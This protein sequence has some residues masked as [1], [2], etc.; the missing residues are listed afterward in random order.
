VIEHAKIDGVIDN[1]TDKT[2]YKGLPVVPIELV[3]DNALVVVVVVIGKPLLA[4]KKAAQHCFEYLDY[5]SLYKYADVP[6]LEVQFQEG[7]RS[8]I[9]VHYDKYNWLFNVLNDDVS[10]SQLYNIVNFRRTSELRFMRGF[11]P[12]EHRQYFEDFL[13]LQE[14]GEVFVDGGYDG[15]TSLEFIKRAPSFRAIYF[16]EP[17][18]RNLNTAKER[19]A[20][21][22]NVHFFQMGLSNERA[23]LTFSAGGSGSKICEGGDLVISVDRLDDL[24]DAPASYIKIDIEGAESLALEGAVETIRRDHPRL[25][26]AAYHRK[27]DLWKL[28]EQILAIRDD[29]DIYLRHYTEGIAETVLFFI[30][31]P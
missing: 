27:D 9:E 7:M 22:A 1:Y 25:A 24:L 8:D 30:P 11:A 29:Y 19:L 13:L 14:D 17:E 5:F 12:I 15:F 3:P 16:F 10:R 4:E 6:L 23:N 26:I 18:L 2:D 20:D 21:Y 28:P 31:K